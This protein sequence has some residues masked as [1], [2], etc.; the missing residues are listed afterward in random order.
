MGEWGSSLEYHT[1]WDTL[2][3]VNPESWLL[4]GVILG[5]VAMEI[6]RGARGMG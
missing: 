3:F 4:S 1:V 6:A 5:T 2:E